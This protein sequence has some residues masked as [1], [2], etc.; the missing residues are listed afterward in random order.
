M[1][2]VLIFSIK[3]QSVRVNFRFYR[4]ITGSPKKHKTWDDF[5]TEKKVLQL[6]QIFE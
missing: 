2:F 5:G 3:K 6:K 4:Q 1:I